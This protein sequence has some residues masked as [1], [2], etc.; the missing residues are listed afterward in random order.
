[1]IGKDINSRVSVKVLMLIGVFLL[2]LL[3]DTVV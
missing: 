1:M 3:F 2:G